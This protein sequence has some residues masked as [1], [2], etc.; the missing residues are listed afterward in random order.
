MVALKKNISILR[1]TGTKKSCFNVAGI[2]LDKTILK[3]KA[4]S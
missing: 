4:K 2:E 1:I 3:F